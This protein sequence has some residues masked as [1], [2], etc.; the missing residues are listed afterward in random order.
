MMELGLRYVL[1]SGKAG[2][3]E[4]LNMSTGGLLFRCRIILPVGELIGADLTWPFPLESGKPLELR[5][6]G[7]ILRSDPAGTAISISK[8]EFRLAPNTV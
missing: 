3:G 7:M 8:Y 4:V 2:T 1:E 5:V 6:R